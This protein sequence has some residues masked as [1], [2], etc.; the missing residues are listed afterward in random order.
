MNI[1]S[2]QKERFMREAIRLARK[3]CG[4]TR[5]N[6]QVGA[7]V[8]KDGRIVGRGYHK[9]AGLPHAEIEALKEAGNLAQGAE[10]YVTLEPC[11]HFGRTPPCVDSIIESGIK[12]VYV[13]TLDPNPIVYKKGIERLKA[14]N[15]D[16]EYGILEEECRKLNEGY[17]VWV[18][19]NR[20]HIT[21]K[22][23][24]TLDGNIADFNYCSK[25]ITSESSRKLVHKLRAASDA[26]LVGIKTVLI[27]NPLLTARGVKTP[28]GQPLRVV[29]DERL[30]MPVSARILEGEAKTLI[31]VSKRRFDAHKDKELKGRAEIVY[32]KEKDGLIDLKALL[33]ELA[34]RNIQ[35][36]LVEGGA[37]VFSSF[38][39]LGLWDKIYLFVAPMILGEGIKW[40][41]DLKLEL[42]HAKRV[43]LI[44]VKRIGGDL[45]LV[46]ER[47]D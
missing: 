7:V 31:A 30:K 4:R 21:L 27:D 38:I 22:I 46:L 45:L 5:P 12:K 11:V 24:T 44:N 47:G 23:A 42:T 13:G 9:R 39:R 15:I 6:P 1:E 17:N 29:L 43:K 33:Q 41:K 28:K 26:V 16:V 25:W 34:S 2:S 3:A 18:S 40:S 19:Q 10:L 37:A 32:L 8:V 14:A 36:L 35:S 20:P